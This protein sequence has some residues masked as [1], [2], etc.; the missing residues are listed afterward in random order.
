MKQLYDIAISET[1]FVFD[2]STGNTYRLNRTGIV[3]FRMLQN[4]NALNAIAE[5]LAEEF[6]V[7][8]DS[9]VE[10]IKEFIAYLKSMR[11]RID[12]L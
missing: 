12:V 10:D 8:K 7:D 5:E 6:E 1:G 11:F 2:P 3:I 4:G 9:T